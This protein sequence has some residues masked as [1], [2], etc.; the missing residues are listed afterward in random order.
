MLLLSVLYGFW[1]ANV[2]AFNGDVARKLAGQFLA[3]AEK[4]RGTIPLMVGHRLMATSLLCTGD[5]PEGWTHYNQALA[6]YDPAA[7]RPL[8]TRFG[9][10]VRMASLSFRSYALWMSGYAEAA[11]ADR[12]KRAPCSGR[13]RNDQPRLRIGTD[14]QSLRRSPYHHFRDHRVSI[15]GSNTV[16]A[17]ALVIFDGAIL[18]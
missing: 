2:V 17:N 9:Q 16:G 7:H 5:I 15:N 8:A 3:L 4:Q 6:L 18:H 13:H 12:K 11:L 1:V 14:R 10:D